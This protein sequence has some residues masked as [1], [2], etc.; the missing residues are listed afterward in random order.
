MT[1]PLYMRSICL[2]DSAVMRRDAALSYVPERKDDAALRVAALLA[3]LD[4]IVEARAAI[5]CGDGDWATAFCCAPAAAVI[6]NSFL[7][8]IATEAFGD[9]ASRATFAL[10]VHRSASSLSPAH[11]PRR[12]VKKEISRHLSPIARRYTLVD[13]RVNGC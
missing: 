1:R 12:G 13:S 7:A 6:D 3:R 10:T 4:G 11:S 8:A 9:E 5:G 2:C